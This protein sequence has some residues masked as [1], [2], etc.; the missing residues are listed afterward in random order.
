MPVEQIAS[1]AAEKQS[2]DQLYDALATSAKGL[3]ADEARRRLEQFGANALEEQK[4]NPVLKFLGYFWGAIPWMIEIA[5]ILSAVVRHWTDFWIIL[6]LLLFNAVI[7][8]WEE[9]QAG[10]ALSALKSQLALKARALRDGKW[11]ELDARDLVPG[12]VVRLR[13][14]DVVPA[15]VKLLDGDYL[16]V[17]QSAL[18]GESLPVEKNPGDVAYSGSVAKQGEMVAVVTTTGANTYFGRTAKLVEKAGAVSHF[19]KAVLTIGDYLIYLSLALAVVLVLTQLFRGQ[20]ALE[21]F[22]FVLILVVAA[23][24]V[25]MPAVLS[26]TM[27]LGALALSRMKAIVARLQSIEEIAGIDILCS[28]KTGTLTQNKLTLG[29]PVAFGGADEEGLILAGAL[30]SK[31][32]DAD[33]IDLAVLHGLKNPERLQG[34][35]QVKFTPFDPVRKRTEAVVQG[36]DGKSFSVCKGAPQV[37]LAICH[38]APEL[39]KDVNAKVEEFAKQG[40]RGLGVARNED[41]KTWRF[42]GVLPLFDPPRE[43]SAETIRQAEE[44]GIQVKMVTGDNTAIAKQIASQL[45]LGTDIHVAEEFFQRDFKP[46]SMSASMAAHVEAAD[47]FAQVFPEHKYD[48]VE[49]LQRRGHIVGMTGDGVNDAP[50]RKAGRRGHCRFGGD[51]RGTR[52]R[53]AD[54]HRAGA[55]SHRQRG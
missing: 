8:F 38:P 30:A 22:Q 50:A 46:E 21:V 55:V 41:G 7:G 4:F 28:D 32:E 39:A 29:M 16:S 14:G 1:D 3:T 44:H 2:V 37:V 53:R 36:A 19:Q 18:T 31:E 24:P 27:A 12:D 40:F 52:R 48:I 34:Y 33:A 47:G 54:S 45:N 35:R 15:D 10:N 26:V 25:A 5:A 43:D 13:L 17:D 49:L 51:R 6:A 20:N 23:I 42:L 9:Y 11:G